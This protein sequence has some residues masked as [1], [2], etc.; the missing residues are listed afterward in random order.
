MSSHP[1]EFLKHPW[2]EP[3]IV[4]HAKDPKSSLVRVLTS[5]ALMF[6][7]FQAVTLHSVC[8][9]GHCNQQAT[10][11]QAHAAAAPVAEHPC[12]HQEAPPTASKG[13]AV[14][15]TGCDCGD[16]AD[17]LPVLVSDS[18]ASVALDP[19]AVHLTVAP[20]DVVSAPLSLEVL[21]WRQATGPPGSRQR[22]FLRFQALLI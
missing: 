12:C 13:P 10:A 19:L 5:A 16:Q 6:F 21:A 20:L 14:R 9:C 2:P 11:D 15:T 4:M 3:E 18:K 8:A 7:A 17:R 1:A 22:L